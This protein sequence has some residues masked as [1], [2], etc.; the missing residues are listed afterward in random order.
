MGPTKTKPAVTPRFAA[1]ADG[2]TVDVLL[3][4]A[5]YISLLVRADVFDAE[6]WPPGKQEGAELLRHIREIEHACVAAHGAFDWEKLD[7]AVQDEYDSLCSK[8]SELQFGSEAIPF[9]DVIAELGIK[10]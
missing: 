5:S 3:D 2:N 1:D 6:Q 4:T 7:P 10:L 9:D 8:L